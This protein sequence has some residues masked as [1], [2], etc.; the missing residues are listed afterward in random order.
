MPKDLKAATRQLDNNSIAGANQL[1]DNSHRM[2]TEYMGATHSSHRLTVPVGRLRDGS[3]PRASS[4]KV[5]GSYPLVLNPGILTQTTQ[6]QENKYEVKPQYEELSKQLIMQHA[7]I[8]DMKCMSAIKD[9]IARPV[10]QLENHLSR[11]SIPRTV[12]QSGKSSVCDLQSPSALHSSVKP[13][14]ALNKNQQQPTDVAFAKEHQNDAASTNKNDAVA[15]QHLTTDF[16]P[17]NQQLVALNNSN[18]V[19]K[20]TSPLMPTADQKRCTQNAAF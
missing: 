14:V 18:D 9:R 15:L 8:N 5:Y 13:A 6:N 19:V 1:E 2:Y 12:Y 7:I 3:Y 17:N 11:A 16:F 10:Y 4:S 20:D